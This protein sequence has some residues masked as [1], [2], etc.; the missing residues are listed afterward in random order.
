MYIKE[1]LCEMATMG[2]NII[3]H[4]YSWAH[5]IHK[6]LSFTVIPNLCNSKT[7]YGP[8]YAEIFKYTIFRKGENNTFV[9]HAKN[10][11]VFA[12]NCM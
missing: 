10:C 12:L 4:E 5:W 8:Q 11:M 9:L 6:S 2:T 1:S 3:T 7:I